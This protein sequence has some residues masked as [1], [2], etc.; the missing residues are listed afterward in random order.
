MLENTRMRNCTRL[1]TA[2]GSTQTTE[3][4][5]CATTMMRPFLVAVA[6]EVIPTAMAATTITASSAAGWQLSDVLPN[7]I[8]SRSLK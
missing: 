8:Y 1:E 2:T 5:S 7:L 6:L 3:T 4:S